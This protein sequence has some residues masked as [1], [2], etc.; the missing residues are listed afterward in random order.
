M[1]AYVLIVGQWLQLLVFQ[2]EVTIL[3]VIK[4]SSSQFYQL[5]LVPTNVIIPTASSLC[6]INMKAPVLLQTV[7]TMV[8]NLGNPNNSKEVCLILGNGSQRSCITESVKERLSLIPVGSEIMII[9]TF[10]VKTHGRQACDIVKVGMN[11]KNGHSLEMLFLSV[12][13]ICEPISNQPTT[14]VCSNNSQFASLELADCCHGDKSLEVDILVGAASWL[15][16][17]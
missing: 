15:L 3:R 10:G 8:H 6:C 11:L 9:K 12:L 4:A 14:F 1:L 16:E 7:C 5:R 17:R 2:R 13:L